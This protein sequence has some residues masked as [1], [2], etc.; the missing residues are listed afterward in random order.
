MWI[1]QKN[2]TRSSWY[3]YKLKILELIK[4][5][6]LVLELTQENSVQDCLLYMLI[7]NSPCKLFLAYPKWLYVC[8]KVN[9]YITY[10]ITSSLPECSTSFHVL[11]DLSLLLSPYHLMLLMCDWVM[12][13]LTLTISSKN[14]IKKNKS[15]IK[16][17]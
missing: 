6:N 16:W 7:S 5:K 15:K 11:C 13:S 12:L 9:M 1:S 17:E 10:Y 3:Y 8:L 4:I 14:R 2:L